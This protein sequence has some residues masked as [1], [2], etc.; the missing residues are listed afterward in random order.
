MRMRGQSEHFKSHFSMVDYV[1]KTKAKR[2]WSSFPIAAVTIATS[3]V[4]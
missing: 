4:A 1:W 3:L 2:G